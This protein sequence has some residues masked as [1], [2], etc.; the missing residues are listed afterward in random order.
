MQT[1]G[2]R[3]IIFIREYMLK[4]NIHKMNIRYLDDNGSGDSFAAYD[5]YERYKGC[6]SVR[7][8]DLRVLMPEG[9]VEYTISAD[10]ESEALDALIGA[11]TARAMA[12]NRAARGERA[13]ISMECPLEDA[14]RLRSLT[15]MGYKVDDQL[16]KMSRIAVD[17]PSAVRIPEGL[18]FISDALEDAAE[19]GYFVK[20]Y[21]LINLLG[22]DEAARRIDEIRRKPNFARL[23]LVSRDGLAGELIC[24]TDRRY[25][26]VGMV[27]TSIEWRRRGV[28]AYLMERSRQ[29]FVR[30]GVRESTLEVRSRIASAV[31]LAAAAGYRQ[32]DVV[33]LFPGIDIN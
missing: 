20:R 2:R 24:W 22:E 14:E 31:K 27:Q 9:V 17:A 10:C 1:G 32:E 28:A 6:C 5:K 23:I 21:A 13:H 3:G 30:S 25:G 11:A 15:L 4:D 33:S 19:Y 18:L 12:M 8:Q 16:I 26:I 7:R 29:H